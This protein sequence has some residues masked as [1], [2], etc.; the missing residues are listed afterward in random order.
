MDR[1]DLLEIVERHATRKGWPKEDEASLMRLDLLADAPD[2]KVLQAARNLA[3]G[4]R[5]VTLETLADAVLKPGGGRVRRTTMEPT[6][7]LLGTVGTPGDGLVRRI[8][9]SAEE[10]R[11]AANTHTDARS[12]PLPFSLDRDSDV[13][14]VD[15]NGW[16]PP[17]P[18]RR[19]VRPPTPLLFTI[20]SLVMGHRSEGR[21]PFS[22]RFYL[23]CGWVECAACRRPL[24]WLSDADDVPAAQVC[25]Q[26]FATTS[27]TIYHR[28]PLVR[29][30][31]PDCFC[32]VR[33]LG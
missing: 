28:N 33:K 6:G 14:C 15:F 4:N 3:A 12:L 21:I 23:H 25:S 32:S 20:R 27:A 5:P 18:Q 22:G 8:L 10:V 2:H 19:Y 17:G 30:P 9:T 11:A 13:F 7:R 16:N 31:R 24:A 26:T 1:S 29:C